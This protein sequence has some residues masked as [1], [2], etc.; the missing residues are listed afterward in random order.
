MQ[1]DKPENSQSTTQGWYVYMVRCS[2]NTYY[3]GITTDL[4]RRVNEHN[5]HRKGARYTRARRPVKL[6]YSEEVTSRSTAAKREYRIRKLPVAA[7]MQLIK[8][9][10]K[11]ENNSEQNQKTE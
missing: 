11:Q 7:K 1:T 9:Y 8:T 10:K 6:A 3:T 2:D 5:S 4:T